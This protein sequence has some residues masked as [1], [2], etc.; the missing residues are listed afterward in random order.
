MGS[1]HCN[2]Q[3]FKGGSLWSLVLY[4]EALGMLETREFQEINSLGKRSIVI[5]GQVRAAVGNRDVVHK[6][7]GGLTYSRR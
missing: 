7:C 3:N 6:A 4:S 5:P 2:V 1:K